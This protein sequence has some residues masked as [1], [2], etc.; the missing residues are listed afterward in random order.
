VSAI[1]SV[2]D[3]DHI[4]ELFWAARAALPA[5]GPGFAAYSGEW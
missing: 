3:P 2:C 1:T 5:A 4:L